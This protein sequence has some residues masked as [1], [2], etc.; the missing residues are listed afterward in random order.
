MDSQAG[1]SQ[2]ENQEE[3]VILDR[4]GT[5]IHVLNWTFLTEEIVLIIKLLETLVPILKV[6]RMACREV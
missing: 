2:N 3:L 1:S 6:G 5:S 4:N